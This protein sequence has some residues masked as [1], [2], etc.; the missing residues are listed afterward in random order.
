MYDES[1]M[2]LL[3]SVDTFR[4][5]FCGESETAHISS[6]TEGQ[7]MLLIYRWAMFALS[8][9]LTRISYNRMCYSPF[10]L[11]YVTNSHQPFA[12]PVFQTS[13]LHTKLAIA[14]SRVYFFTFSINPFNHHNI[15]G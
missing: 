14:T 12:K 1:A 4:D 3:G 7:H 11:A 9:T 15:Q 8:A 6:H 5:L 2:N 13:K 10:A